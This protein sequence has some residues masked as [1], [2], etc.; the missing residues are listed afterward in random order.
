MT[1][2]PKSFC[3]G[4][5][6]ELDAVTAVTQPLDAIMPKPG[7]FSVCLKCGHVMAFSETL[8]LRTMT[9][10]EMHNIAGDKRLLAAQQVAAAYRAE[11]GKRQD[12][13]HGHDDA[14]IK[15]LARVLR[16]GFRWP[17]KV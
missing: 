3:L 9:G 4:C 11:H 7:D 16:S 13:N 2:V 15:M 14:R 8:T 1:D 5:G 10:A 6:A 17:K 12:D